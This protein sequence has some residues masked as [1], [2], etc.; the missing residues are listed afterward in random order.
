MVSSSCLDAAS[1]A[2]LSRDTAELDAH[3]GDFSV[4]HEHG[5]RQGRIFL[6]SPPQKSGRIC[7]FFKVTEMDTLCRTP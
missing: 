5:P 3:G 2:V 6:P 1:N 7:R 4:S